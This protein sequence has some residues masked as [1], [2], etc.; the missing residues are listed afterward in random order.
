VL[1]RFG[2][3]PEQAVAIGDNFNDLAMFTRVGVSVA[4]YN[5]PDEVKERAKVV[6]PSND[7]EGVAWVLMCYNT[8][9]TEFEERIL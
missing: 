8:A 5:A 2:V 6:A 1:D 9:P 3:K 4:M 7:G